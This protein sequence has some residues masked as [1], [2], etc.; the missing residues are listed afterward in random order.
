MEPPTIKGFDAIK[1]SRK[2][3]QAAARRCADMTREE[4][5]A[6]LQKIHEESLAYRRKLLK[7]KPAALAVH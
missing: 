5:L 3:K 7:R 6:Y 1:E 2:W 4:Y